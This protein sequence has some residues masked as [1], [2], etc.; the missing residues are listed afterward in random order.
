MEEERREVKK[1]I[2]L[3]KVVSRIKGVVSRIKG[4]V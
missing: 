2:Y 1:N 3:R 4:V